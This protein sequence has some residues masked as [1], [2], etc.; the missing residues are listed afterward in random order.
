MMIAVTISFNNLAMSKYVQRYY[1]IE[2]T[3]QEMTVL[4]V[5]NIIF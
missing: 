3:S 5:N 1:S 4:F 2:L